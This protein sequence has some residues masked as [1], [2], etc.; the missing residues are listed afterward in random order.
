MTYSLS[1]QAKS[2]LELYPEKYQGD[3]AVAEL[4][5][6]YMVV[7]DMAA[8][9]KLI[10][11]AT[12]SMVAKNWTEQGHGKN[13]YCLHLLAQIDQ[14]L[15]TSGCRLYL[16]YVNTNLNVADNPSRNDKLLEEDRIRETYKVLQTALGGARGIWWRAGDTAGG[17]NN[18]N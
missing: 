16:T 1:G 3:I 18:N 7:R 8:N 10:V 15:E 9:N 6:I 17:E 2:F 4:Y 14:L 11:L 12:D 5:A 13:N